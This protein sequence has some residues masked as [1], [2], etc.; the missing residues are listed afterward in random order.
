MAVDTGSRSRGVRSKSLFASAHAYLA[1][2]DLAALTWR[3]SAPLRLR[4]LDDVD[5]RLSRLR[6]RLSWLLL[7]PR[8]PR[9]LLLLLLLRPPL[10]RP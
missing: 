8:P 2:A 7:R 1:V 6:S 5:A 9:R 10:L 3:D 4:Q